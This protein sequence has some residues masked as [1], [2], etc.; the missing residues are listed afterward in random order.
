[1]KIYQSNSL[2]SPRRVR[3]FL[4]EKGIEDVEMV[5]LDVA[6]GEARQPEFLARNPL[7]EVP[8]LELD[9]GDH[10]G[11]VTAISRYFEEVRPF[12]ALF[13]GTPGDKARVE[14]WLRRIESGLMGAVAAYYHHATAGFGDA[15]RYRNRE[16]GENSRDRA[17]A[18]M[19][20]L[21]GALGTDEFVAGATFSVADIA[22][23][24]AIDFAIACGIE[25]PSAADNLRAWHDRV[26]RRPS[27]AA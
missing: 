5:T 24:C 3:M 15:G 21:D 18:T 8:V 9:D 20:L 25:I 17:T 16:W 4:A 14:M 10:I 12:P 2:P 19:Q 22:A 23:L 7:G 6:G 13:G 26:S 11:E 27:A 1:M